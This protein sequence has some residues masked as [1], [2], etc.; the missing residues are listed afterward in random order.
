LN[1]LSIN[2]KKKGKLDYDQ[3]GGYFKD[4]VFDFMNVFNFNFGT[5]IVKSIDI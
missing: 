1:Y 4:K 3:V 2:S 5:K